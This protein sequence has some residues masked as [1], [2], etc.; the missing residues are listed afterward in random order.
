[1]EDRYDI[2]QFNSIVQNRRS[3][4][5]YQF[6]KGKAVPD[7]VIRQILENANRAPTHKLTQPWRFTVFSGKGREVFSEMQTEI[8]TKYAGENFKEK[9]LQ[10][11]RDYPLFSSHV[12]V[13]GMKRTLHISIPETEEIIAVGCAIENI[14]LSLNAYNLGGYISLVALLILMKPNPILNLARTTG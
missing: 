14:F 13:V 12:I 11:L 8:Y 10:N 3:I 2:N 1:M 6:I 5:P 7:P 9:K 4:Y